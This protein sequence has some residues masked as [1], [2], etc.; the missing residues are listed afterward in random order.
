MKYL[1]IMVKSQLQ[2]SSK[3]NY[4][5]N[6]LLYITIVKCF[7]PSTFMLKMQRTLADKKKYEGYAY[8]DAISKVKELLR[9]I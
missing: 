7:F 1:K 4:R 8:V 5:K 3:N 9:K 2:G 6:I